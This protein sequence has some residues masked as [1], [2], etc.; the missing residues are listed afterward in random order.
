[1]HPAKNI[2][3]QGDNDSLVIARID[4]ENPAYGGPF[5][6]FLITH[7]TSVIEGTSHFETPRYHLAIGQLRFVK[8][9]LYA[10]HPS[11]KTLAIVWSN[12]RETESI[13]DLSRVVFVDERQL[14][15]EEVSQIF[16]FF[17]TK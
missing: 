13:G 14:T 12:E 7:G 9:I 16:A 1:M 3:H 2:L 4:S 10:A 15:S 6:E 11:T 17:F 5:R 8:K